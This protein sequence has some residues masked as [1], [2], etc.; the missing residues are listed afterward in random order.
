[1]PKLDLSQQDCDEI[2]AFCDYAEQHLGEWGPDP[3]VLMVEWDK[4]VETRSLVTIELNDG[5]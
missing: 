1:M 3:S 5:G 4:W 2:K